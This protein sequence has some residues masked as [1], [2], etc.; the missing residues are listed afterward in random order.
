MLQNLIDGKSIMVQ[1]TAW[2]RQTMTCANSDPDRCRNM[3]S[4][5][6]AE[7]STISTIRPISRGP[8]TGVMENRRKMVYLSKKR[9]TMEKVFAYA[10]HSTYKDDITMAYSVSKGNCT[11][12]SWCIF[13]IHFCS[14]THLETAVFDDN[15]YSVSS[16][17]DIN[18]TVLVV[19]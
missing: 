13:Q 19:T 18:A 12:L 8:V 15:T 7:L 2:C 16:W 17:D 14:R 1:A 3:T 10:P 11:A 6:H 5:S 9:C 4:L